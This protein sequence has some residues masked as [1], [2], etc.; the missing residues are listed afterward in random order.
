VRGSR[1]GP[2]FPKSRFGASS[3]IPDRWENITHEHFCLPTRHTDI[4]DLI[5]THLVTLIL[6]RFSTTG[7]ASMRLYRRG[8]MTARVRR[9]AHRVAVPASKGA[10]SSVPTPTHHDAAAYE[11]RGTYWYRGAARPGRCDTRLAK[12]GEHPCCRCQLRRLERSH[13]R[14]DP[15]EAQFDRVLPPAPPGPMCLVPL[16]YWRS[17]IQRSW[18][19]PRVSFVKTAGESA[20]HPVAARGGHRLPSRA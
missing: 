11:D 2:S 6:N 4:R 7:D 20:T 3:T 14:E 10:S 8:K 18:S 5:R 16:R 15:S 12:C 9:P 17:N 19:C 1:P 13:G